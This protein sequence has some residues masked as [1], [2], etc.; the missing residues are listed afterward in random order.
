ME[1]HRPLCSVSFRTRWYGIG[2]NRRKAQATW[3]AAI[4]PSRAARVA[5]GRGRPIRRGL[6]RSCRGGYAERRRVMTYSSTLSGTTTATSTPSAASAGRYGATGISAR[7]T[8]AAP[9]RVL[10]TMP[11]I[12]QRV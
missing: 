7:T 10:D 1:F 6:S 8:S 3:R 11:N 9:S 2:C 5:W 12:R 4:F